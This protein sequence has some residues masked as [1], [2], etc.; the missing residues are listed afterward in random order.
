MGKS[1]YTQEEDKLMSLSDAMKLVNDGDKVAFGGALILREPMAAIYELIRQKKRNL[2]IIG[3]AHGFDVDIACGGGIVKTEQHTYVAYEFVYRGGC[4]NFRRAVEEG[5]VEEKEDGC[6][7]VIQGLRAASYGI[8]F[9]PSTSYFGTDVIKF[10][11]EYKEFNCPIT[12]RKLVAIPAIKPDVAILH[13]NVADRHGN[14]RL[15]APIVADILMQRAADKVIIT[16]EELVSEDWFKERHAAAIPYY[17][18]TAVVHLPFGA[19]PTCLYPIYT[20]DKEFLDE[21]IGYMGKGQ[22]GVEEWFNKYVYDISHEQYLERIGGEKKLEKLRDWKKKL[23][24]ATE[25]KKQ[26][27]A[28]WEV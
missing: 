24:E 4:P 11:P 19:H 20:Y 7:A 5:L 25:Y 21:Y 9:Y 22:A 14:A 23:S 28:M 26:L 3:T 10:H 12:G 16:T 13:T 6:Y 8:P 18:T 15:E 17:E 27:E 2:H 1:I